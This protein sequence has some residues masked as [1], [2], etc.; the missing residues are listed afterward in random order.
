VCYTRTRTHLFKLKRDLILEKMSKYEDWLKSALKK[1]DEDFCK[2]SF[3][4]R[5][6]FDIQSH[7]WC[8]LLITRNNFTKLNQNHQLIREFALNDINDKIDLA[9]IKS[10]SMYEYEPRLLIEFKETE[11]D[12]LA[13]SKIDEIIIDINKLR[14][15]MSYIKKNQVKGH[16]YIRRPWFIFFFRGASKQGI[17]LKPDNKMR[18]LDRDYDDIHFWWGPK[19]I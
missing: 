1:L 8:C 9:I 2:L 17:G 12:H 3:L 5:N 4:P 18:K 13:D 7:L 19:C 16:N 14:S 10:K 15:M 6:E 11:K